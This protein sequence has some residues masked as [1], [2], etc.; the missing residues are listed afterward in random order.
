MAATILVVEDEAQLREVLRMTLERASYRVIVAESGNAG[1]RHYRESRPDL[2]LTDILLPEMDG[3]EVLR[4]V[5]LIDS[6]AR[7]IAMSGGGQAADMKFREFT[8]EFGAVESLA[9]P[10]R[11]AQL[12]TAVERVLSAPI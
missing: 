12:L 3:L 4:A 7:I 9:K 6:K 10:F 11:A 8:K 1:I 5:R 2:I